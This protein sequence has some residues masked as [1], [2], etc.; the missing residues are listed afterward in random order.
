MR[1]ALDGWMEKAQVEEKKKKN[2]TT[3]AILSARAN[4]QIIFP[5]NYVIVW[6]YRKAD[7]IFS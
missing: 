6:V 5:F 7:P 3:W 2:K 4:D 1:R